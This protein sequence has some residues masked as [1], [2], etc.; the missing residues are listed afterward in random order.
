MPGL[1]KRGDVFIYRRMVPPRPEHLVD[2]RSRSV[3]WRE[4]SSNSAP[5]RASDSSEAPSGQRFDEFSSWREP[6]CRRY[7]DHPSE[8]K[9]APLAPDA[10]FP[11]EPLARR[12]DAQTFSEPDVTDYGA[13]ILEGAPRPEAGGD[14]VA[15]GSRADERRIE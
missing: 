3:A 13:G 15:A 11:P 1:V 6:R 4:E 2:Q 7:R 8:V 14:T 5:P 12:R 9:F 10:P